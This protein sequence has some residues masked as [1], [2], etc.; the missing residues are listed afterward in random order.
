MALNRS[1]LSVG[2]I[3]RP[4]PWPPCKAQTLRLSPR[5]PLHR[6]RA[7]YASQQF[8]SQR[9]LLL[10]VPLCVGALAFFS[11]AEPSPVPVILSCPSVIPCSASE[12]KAASSYD[13]HQISSPIEA[14]HFII[15]RI[16]SW[17]RDQIWEPLRTSAR[18]IHLLILFAPVLIT[19][20]MLLL[21]SRKRRRDGQRWGAIWWYGL[22]VAQMQRAG[23]TFIKLAQWAATRQDL[24]PSALCERFGSL[25]SQGKS[26]SIHHTKRII[27]GAFKRPFDQVFE[28]FDETPIGVGAIAQVYRAI[29]NPELIPPSYLDPKHKRDHKKGLTGAPRVAGMIARDLAIMRFFATCLNIIP[30]FEWLSLVDEVDVFGGM[31]SEQLDLR[32]EA[33]NLRTFENN[34]TGRMSA[35]TFPRPLEDFSTTDVLVEEY[36]NAL[37]L[38]AFLRNGGGPFD[39]SLANLGLDAFLNMLLLDN[40]VHSDL[41]PGNIMVKF[42]KPSTKSLYQ[43]ILASAFGTTSR[44]DSLPGSDPDS[45][46]SMHPTPSDI[47]D[48][49]VSRLRPLSHDPDAWLDALSRLAE[50]GFQP[51]L[52]FI[53]TGLVTTLNTTNRRNFLDLFRAIAEFD[54]YRAGTLMVERCR[55]PELA[56]DPETFALKTQHLVLGVKSKTFSLAKIKISDILTQVLINGDFIN[57]VISILLLEGI[58]RQLDPDM[59]LLKSALPILRQLGTQITAKEA[60]QEI[61]RGNLA[62]MLKI[63]VWIEARELV[64][65]A[66]INVDDMIKYDWL[67]P[68][69]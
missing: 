13:T 58:G 47:S 64:T 48:E 14:R 52:V 25:H 55:T 53:D 69:V 31:M 12:L 41:H 16:L 45:Q 17:L 24:F 6:L 50:E 23:P 5:R 44:P 2:G 43:S 19:T 7:E 33:A 67:S 57:T 11:P 21:G 29:L 40:F 37:P 34:F 30:G 8:L 42:Y 26:H 15:R 27:E 36:Q 35:V 22:L 66:N 65:L 49:I 63:W 54:G 18:F 20:P 60:I 51:S 9:F 32:R 61:P 28:S 59:D 3:L 62:A 38:K 10:S 68:N 39:N 4:R 56:V 1:V 46:S